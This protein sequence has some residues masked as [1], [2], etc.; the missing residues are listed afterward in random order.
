MTKYEKLNEKYPFGV[1][2]SKEGFPN[3]EP[4]VLTRNGVKIDVDI[5]LLSP[6]GSREDFRRADEVMREQIPGW[7]KPGTATWHHVQHSTRLQLIPSDLHLNV[8]HTGGRATY[9]F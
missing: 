4:Y 8:R 6:S 1:N 7:T 3:F 2:F 5:G 9:N